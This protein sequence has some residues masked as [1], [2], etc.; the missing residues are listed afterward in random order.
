MGRGMDEDVDVDDCV[1]TEA[2]VLPVD[3]AAE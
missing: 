3:V 1:V 2:V